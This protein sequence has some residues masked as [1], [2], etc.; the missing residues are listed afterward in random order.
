VV[1]SSAAL[2][3]S[4][5]IA[6]ASAPKAAGNRLKPAQQR[7]TQS[8]VPDIWR[9]VQVSHASVVGEKRRTRPEPEPASTGEEKLWSRFQSMASFKQ[10]N[11]TS[12]S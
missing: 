8:T 1:K 6:S 5:N 4:A 3:R 10:S 2:H 9:W 7:A 12:F 11:L